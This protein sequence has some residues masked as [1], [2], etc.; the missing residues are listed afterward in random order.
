MNE[1]VKITASQLSRYAVVYLRQSGAA[2]VERNRESTD[3][4]MRS[5]ARRA[6]SA[7]PTNAS[8]SSTRT[9]A[10]PVSARRRVRALPASPP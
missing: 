3:P 4:N 5:P 2:Q 1:R 9:A 8:S 6:T 10:F 7:G